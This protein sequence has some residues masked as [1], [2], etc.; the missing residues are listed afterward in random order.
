MMAVHLLKRY[1]PLI[2]AATAL[3]LAAIVG[4]LLAKG[5]FVLLIALIAAVVS[6]LVSYKYM[7]PF[8]AFVV[9]LFIATAFIETAF[10]SINVGPSPLPARSLASLTAL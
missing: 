3:L 8:P 10:F 5:F 1:H 6:V 7:R 4:M 2:Q 9:K